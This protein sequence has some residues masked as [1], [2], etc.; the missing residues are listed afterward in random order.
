[1][2]T[3]LCVKEKSFTYFSGVIFHKIILI[4][5]ALERRIQL[6]WTK[7]YK[8]HERK[9]SS[10]GT[11]TYKSLQSNTSHV[12]MFLGPDSS[13]PLIANDGAK[14]ESGQCDV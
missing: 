10:G 14:N 9:L 12:F 8:V 7:I 3:D 6:I 2:V 13:V 5:V 4:P 1:M 11:L